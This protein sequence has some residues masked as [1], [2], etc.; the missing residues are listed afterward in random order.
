MELSGESYI[1]PSDEKINHSNRLLIE[2]YWKTGFGK[3]TSEIKESKKGW[4]IL[5]VSSELVEE[6]LLSFLVHKDFVD[7]RNAHAKYLNSI[8][9]KHSVCDVVLISINNHRIQKPFRLGAQDR[10][11]CNSGRGSLENK[12]LQG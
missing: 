4:Y 8:S 7:Q 11:K 3:S 9:E 2:K 5:D 1:L 10:E 12:W 6:F